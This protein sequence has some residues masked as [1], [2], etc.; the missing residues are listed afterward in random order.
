MPT[1]SD[2]IAKTLRENIMR[3]KDVSIDH[4]SLP[5]NKLIVAIDTKDLES[6]VSLCSNL[7]DVVGSFKLGLEFFMANG[8]YGTK[9]IAGFGVP[10]F[11]DLKFHDIPNTVGGAI[12]SLLAGTNKVFMITVHASGGVEMLKRA[13]ESAGDA[14]NVM[15]VTALTSLTSSISDVLFMAEKVTESGCD[16]VVCSGLEVAA[17]KEKFPDLKIVVPGVRP[18]WYGVQDDQKRVVTP[19]KATQD[20]ADFIVVGRPITKSEN[21]R[22]AAMDI[23]KEFI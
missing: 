17:I 4:I 13:K 22:Q 12:E 11:L 20:G 23:L 3:R 5:Q 19:Q 21:P 10:I 18:S 1:R 15:G 8:L 9:R 2:K 14:V 6:A 16:G 7:K